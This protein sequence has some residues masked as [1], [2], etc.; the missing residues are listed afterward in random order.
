M[1]I[2]TLLYMA[3]YA[4][5]VCGKRIKPVQCPSV[6]PFVCL[7]QS[8]RQQQSRASAGDAHRQ[9]HM[10]GGPRKFWSDCKEVQHICFIFTRMHVYMVDNPESGALPPP[11][12]NY[13][14]TSNKSTKI[15]CL[16][17]R[18]NQAIPVYLHIQWVTGPVN[19]VRS[20]THCVSHILVSKKLIF[21]I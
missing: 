14:E 21:T 4:H 9:L 17:L 2:I 16:F 7:S 3:Y 12:K 19:K 1:Y 15:D 18:I 5:G 8:T 20:H 11:K 13:H 10:I 6:R